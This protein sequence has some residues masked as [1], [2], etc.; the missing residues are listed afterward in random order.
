MLPDLMYYNIRNLP[1]YIINNKQ[2][3]IKNS[4]DILPEQ[5]PVS[6]ELNVIWIV[7]FGELGKGNNVSIKIF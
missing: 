4:P 5:Y 2:Q 3:N 1:E 7:S 6:D